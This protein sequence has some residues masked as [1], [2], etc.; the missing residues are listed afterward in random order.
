MFII[1]IISSYD[2]DYNIIILFLI[3]QSLSVL[4]VWFLWNLWLKRF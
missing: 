2:H 4:T 1:I 3:I